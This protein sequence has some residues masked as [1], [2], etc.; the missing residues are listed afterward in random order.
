[1]YSKIFH[2]RKVKV[3]V[4]DHTCEQQWYIASFL[5]YLGRFCNFTTTKD[6]SNV[7]SYNRSDYI[8]IFLVT[9]VVNFKC[10]E[11]WGCL[12]C[13]LNIVAYFLNSEEFEQ[14][15]QK[16]FRISIQNLSYFLIYPDK[17]EKH[18]YYPNNQKILDTIYFKTIRNKFETMQIIDDIWSYTNLDPREKMAEIREIGLYFKE[19]GLNPDSRAGAIAVRFGNGCLVNATNTDKNDITDD[20]ISYVERYS[21]KKN[22]VFWVGQ[23]IPSSESAVAMLLFNHWPNAQCFLHFHCKQ[24]TYSPQLN[25]YRTSKYVTYGTPG[26]AL[27]LLRKFQ[28]INNNFVIAHGHGEFLIAQSLMDAKK[29]IKELLEMVEK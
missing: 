10:L 13:S 5:T 2:N 6:L 9:S 25:Y 1:M 22:S 17:K 20:R 24:L 16:S 29:H 3:F 18:L 21:V 14:V 23:H 7:Q 26:E 4:F 19:M 15:N 27:F 8:L 12:D 28:K 11:E